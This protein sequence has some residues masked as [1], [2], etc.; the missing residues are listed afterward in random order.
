MVVFF[1]AWPRFCVAL[2]LWRRNAS[3]AGGFAGRL[4]VWCCSLLVGDRFALVLANCAMY[5]F[6]PCLCLFQDRATEHLR[7]NSRKK[8][9]GGNRWIGE[10]FDNIVMANV[11][12]KTSSGNVAMVNWFQ[13]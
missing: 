2:L 13:K 6:S 5:Y 12:H 1:W 3:L 8:N 9:I 11:R 4:V 7:P 10:V